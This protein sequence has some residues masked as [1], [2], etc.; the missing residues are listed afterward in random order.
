MLDV[1]VTQKNLLAALAAVKAAVPSRSP[2]P[3]LETVKL[4]ADAAGMTVTATDLDLTVRVPLDAKIE[5]TGEICVSY[6]RLDT[7]TRQTTGALRLLGMQASK[8]KDAALSLRVATTGSFSVTLPATPAVEFPSLPKKQAEAKYNLVSL[9]GDMVNELARV[10]PFA[11]TEESRPILN[12]TLLEFPKG[13]V[14]AVATNGHRLAL[15]TLPLDHNI[16][17]DPKDKKQPSETNVIVPGDALDLV[18][19]L[20]ARTD[21]LTLV[22]S[23]NDPFVQFGGPW[24]TVYARAIEGPYPHYRQ[25]IPRDNDKAAVMDTKPFLAMLKRLRPFSSDATRRMRLDFGRVGQNVIGQTKTP[26]LGEA[27]DS[28]DVTYEGEP[29]EIGFNLDY[30]SQAVQA[31]DTETFMLSMHQPERAAILAAAKSENGAGRFTLLLMP[32]QLMDY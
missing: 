11:S 25:V 10:T 13:E 27:T 3:I 2:L 23:P 21:R 28:L 30:L 12:G 7:V 26:D 8:K 29:I 6:K 22:W 16:A 1:T 15:R 18:A 14:R 20:A 4:S 31:L 24:G 9:S 19:K 5:A 17:R 32:L